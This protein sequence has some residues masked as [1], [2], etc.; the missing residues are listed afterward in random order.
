MSIGDG[1]TFSVDD[2]SPGVQID[3]DQDQD[4][5]WTVTQ[6]KGIMSPA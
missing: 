4:G 2:L 3:L 5:R 1:I 6:S